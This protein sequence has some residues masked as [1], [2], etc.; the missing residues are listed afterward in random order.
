[1]KRLKFICYVALMSFVYGALGA[2]FG[3]CRF[4]FFGPSTLRFAPTQFVV[5][6]TILGTAFGLCMGWDEGSKQYLAKTS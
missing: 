2:F 5:L 3:F 1:M 4:L 6:C